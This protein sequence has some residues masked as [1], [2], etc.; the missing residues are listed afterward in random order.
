[1]WTKQ[2]YAGTIIFWAGDPFNLESSA[3]GEKQKNATDFHGLIFLFRENPWNPW[4]AFC[5][6]E[7]KGCL[8]KC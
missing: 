2:D 5:F 3:A 6:W 1:M 8:L 7:K 4:H